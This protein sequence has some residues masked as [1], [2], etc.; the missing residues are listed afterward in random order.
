M[1]RH[2]PT[3]SELFALWQEADDLANAAER[4]ISAQLTAFVKGEGPAPN[5]LHLEVATALRVTARLRLHAADL[6]FLKP[7]LNRGWNRRQ[8]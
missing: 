1:M 7:T 8:P 2:M 6:A 5:P 3:R 4:M